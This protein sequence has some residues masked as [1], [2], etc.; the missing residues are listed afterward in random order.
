VRFT[1][2]ALFAAKHSPEGDDLAAAVAAIGG[3]DDLR[4]GIDD[5]LGDR[6]GGEA[7]EDDA[8]GRADAGAGEDGDREL[9][10]HGHVDGDDIALL[11]A[12]GFQRVGALARRN[13]KLAVG[14]L[15]DLGVV[16][17][18]VGRDRVAGVRRDGLALPHEADEIAEAGLDVAVDAV[19]TGVEFSAGEP[20]RIG[21]LPIKDPGE[22]LEPGE[23]FCFLGPEALGV[24]DAARV[25]SL[26]IPH[27]RDV[28]VA[29]AELGGGLGGEDAGLVEEGGGVGGRCG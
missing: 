27:R 4:V 11:D 2:A 19:V 20:L 3:D 7:A 22:G 12:E 10:D 24:A 5:A 1:L 26:V 28:V 13:L 8:V 6:G 18:V 25:E 17:V 14:E 15:L 23:V 29:E 21:G 9:G 16:G